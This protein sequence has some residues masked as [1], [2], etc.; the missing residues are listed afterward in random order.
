MVGILFLF[1]IYTVS[2][3]KKDV[4]RQDNWRST[5]Y[6]VLRSSHPLRDTGL[7]GSTGKLQDDLR[8]GGVLR[9]VIASC[10]SSSSNSPFKSPTSEVSQKLVE[11]LQ[12]EKVSR[13]AGEG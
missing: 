2:C 8:E 5:S 3:S 12:R 4:R 11:G 6:G 13:K 10:P 7:G 1:I 9:K